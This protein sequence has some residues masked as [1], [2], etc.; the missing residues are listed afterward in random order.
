LLVFAQG[1]AGL[2]GCPHGV[3]Q[4]TLSLGAGGWFRR[5]PR[6]GDDQPGC[7][8]DEGRGVL[9]ARRQ[10]GEQN[11]AERIVVIVSAELRQTQDIGRQ[12]GAIV[13]HAD[14]VAQLVGLDGAVGLLP[15][16]DAN[17]AGAAE[18]DFDQTAGLHRAE[19][20]RQAIVEQP[21]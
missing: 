12:R 14:Y 1:V 18:R 15:E 13:E 5:A 7:F 10:R 8:R 3:E 9:Q 6:L 19:C 4:G 21:V 20:I 17:L 16:H 11:R 2:R